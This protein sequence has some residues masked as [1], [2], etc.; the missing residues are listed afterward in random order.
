MDNRRLGGAWIAAVLGGVLLMGSGAPASAE[1]VLSA[2]QWREDLH[3][4]AKQIPETN[5]RAFHAVSAPAFAAEVAA[6]DAEIPTLSDHQVEVEFARLVARLGEGHSRVSL[7]GLPDPMTDL[8]EITPAKDAR[9]AFHRA[10]IRLYAFSDGLFVVAAT[11]AFKRLVGA[12]VLKIAGHPADEVLA[13]VRPIANRDNEMGVRLIAPDLVV[14]PEVLQALNL[15]ED[16]RTL[17]VILRLPGGAEQ[18]VELPT[19]ESDGAPQWDAFMPAPL[20]GRHAEKNFW[21]EYRPQ[22]GVLYARLRVI[23]DSPELTVAAFARSLEALATA[24]PVRKVVLD[25]RNCHGGDN[26]RFRALLLQVIREP[27]LDRPGRLFVLIDRGTF[28]AAV[29]SASDLE[30]LANAIFVGEPTGGAPSSWGD[31]KRITLPNSGLI[32]RISTIYWR[33]WTTDES[34]PWI[35]PEISTPVSSADYFAGGDPA[36]AAVLAFP[37]REGPDDLLGDL[38]TAGADSRALIRFYYQWKT[39]PQLAERATRMPMQRAGEAFLARRDYAGAQ[40]SFTINARD[41]PASLPDALRAADAA[42]RTD[43]KDPALAD[44]AH[45][46]EAMRPQ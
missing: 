3:Y 31:P 9:L 40:L 37:V 28:S 5:P 12:Q 30:R 16:A 13:A 42:R 45:K 43:P 19:I 6:L 7:P 24:H 8:A 18:R 33:D 27:R 23:R 22:D 35:A 46:L 15:T 29:N 36:M 14:V 44:L 34:R 39:D 38:V 25:L 4:L 21:A 11:P 32:A 41:Y 17:A 10:P 20:A 2:K 1:G 26:Q